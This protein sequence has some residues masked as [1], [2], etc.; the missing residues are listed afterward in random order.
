MN[1]KEKSESVSS[2][3]ASCDVQTSVAL[4]LSQHRQT[5]DSFDNIFLFLSR[6]KSVVSEKP[7]NHL[8]FFDGE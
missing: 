4:F 6:K 1:K 2:C 5:S 3:H 8:Y 7:N